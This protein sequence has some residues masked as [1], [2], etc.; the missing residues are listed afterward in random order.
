VSV[1]QSI[2]AGI[3]S[4]A[5]RMA[6]SGLAWREAATQSLCGRSDQGIL[7]VL[8]GVDTLAGAEAR[9]RAEARDRGTHTS[10]N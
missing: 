2:E 10:P 7:Q 6:G 8:C 5:W 3:A 1:K 4:G 9:V